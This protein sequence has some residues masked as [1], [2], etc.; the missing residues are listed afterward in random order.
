M[1]RHGKVFTAE[2]KADMCQPLDNDGYSSDRFDDLYGAKNNPHK[3]TDRDRK[4]KKI[5]GGGG[6]FISI[7][8]GAWKRIFKKK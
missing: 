5:R 3:N 6:K 4:H 8:R 1:V 7:S 2:D